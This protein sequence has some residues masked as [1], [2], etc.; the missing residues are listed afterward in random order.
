MTG[1]SRRFG[2]REGAV[3]WGIFRDL[4]DPERYVET[5]LVITWAE[6]MRQHARVT[7][8]DQE[9][10][11]RTFSFRQPGIEPFAAHLIA[12]RTYDQLTAVEPPYTELS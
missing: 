3:R 7:V 4:A 8:E 11:A 12:A 6:H 10:E 9:T 5:F 2:R 1:I